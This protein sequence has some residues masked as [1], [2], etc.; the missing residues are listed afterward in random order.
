M[1]LLSIPPVFFKYRNLAEFSRNVYWTRS[2]KLAA[3]SETVYG[4]IPLHLVGSH[5]VKSLRVTGSNPAG[6]TCHVSMW[7]N[8]ASNGTFRR[9]IVGA[10]PSGN[11]FDI[12]VAP[13][14]GYYVTNPTDYNYAIYAYASG[15]G[16]EIKLFNI[17][18]EVVPIG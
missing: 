13:S 14:G 11:P 2:D 8:Y 12:T 7:E 10:N 3:V 1:G 9:Q 15:S 17:E 6:G 4:M 18:M 16:I 5:K